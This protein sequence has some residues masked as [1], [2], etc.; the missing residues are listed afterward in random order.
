MVTVAPVVG[1]VMEGGNSIVIIA[2]VYIVCS[3]VKAILMS[4]KSCTPYFDGLTY[5]MVTA[6][7]AKSCFVMM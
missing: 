4:V 3:V 1:K 7:G 5:W 2:G 6:P